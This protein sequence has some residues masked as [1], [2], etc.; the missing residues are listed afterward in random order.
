ME[1]SNVEC[2]YDKTEVKAK[3]RFLYQAFLLLFLDD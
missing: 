3:E 1:D 2:V